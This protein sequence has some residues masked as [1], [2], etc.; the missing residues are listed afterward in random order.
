V[1]ITQ[2][3]VG[4]DQIGRFDIVVDDD[5]NSIVDYKWKLIPIDNNLAE[6]DVK[7]KEFI[8]S[9][10][11][12]VDRKYSCL[13]SKFAK[14]LTHPKREIETALGNL[15]ADIFAENSQA[16]VMFVGSGSIRVKELGPLVTLKDFL[17]CF[18]YD[19][20]L[21]RFEIKGEQLKKIFAHIMRLTNRDGEGEC[22]QVNGAVKAVYDDQKKQLKSLLINN[23]E[24][25]GEKF[26]T[27]C[28]Q[29]FHFNNCQAYLD[30]TNDK[31]LKTGKHKAVT[32]SAQN[33]LEEYLRTHQNLKSMIEGRLVY[34]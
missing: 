19:D 25:S 17:A 21:H 28:L 30:I 20:S 6:P 16:D 33:V 12:D 22:Y 10:K 4:S 14:K 31:L 8:D 7:L 1:L 18:P 15:I 24:V 23:T 27:I 11:K 5:T 29:G 2:A 34:N 32:T 13:I 3:G 9:F 26:Y